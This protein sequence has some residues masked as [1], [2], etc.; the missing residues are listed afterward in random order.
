MKKIRLILTVIMCVLLV[1]VM[2]AESS[3]AVNTEKLTFYMLIGTGMLNIF[4]GVYKYKENKKI[5][6][7]MM[8]LLGYLLIRL[9]LL[10][11]I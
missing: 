7:I 9:A 1:A 8:F 4:N 2:V 5:Y 6:S 3:N 10:K 11:Y